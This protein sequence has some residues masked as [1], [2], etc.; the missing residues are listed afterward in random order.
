[1]TPNHP[2]LI[3]VEDN[4][5]VA[6]TVCHLAS[7]LGFAP[8]HFSSATSFRQS[9]TTITPSAIILDLGLPDDD[10]ITLID[11]IH[12]HFAASGII[13]MSGKDPSV[14]HATGELV[15]THGLHLIGTLH[16]PFHLKALQQLLTVVR[17]ERRRAA[18]TPDA[19]S[20]TVTME[21]LQ[22]ALQN[23]QFVPFYQPQTT[24]IEATVVGFE[25]LMRWNHPQW[26]IVAP[27]RFIHLAAQHRLL[28]QMTWDMLEQVASH[29][30]QLAWSKTTVSV[31]LPASFLSQKKLPE[32][33]L[34][35]ISRYGLD[36]SQLMLEITESEALQDIPHQL[37]NLIRLRLAGFP[38]SIDDFGTGY[39]S[40]VSLYQTPFQELK[41]DQ[42]F[43][44]RADNDAIALEIIHTL[45]FL[46]RRLNIQL[47]AEGVETESVRAL[48]IDAGVERIQGYLVHKPMPFSHLQR[49]REA[50]QARPSSAPVAPPS[51]TMPT[52]SLSPK[53]LLATVRNSLTMTDHTI[54][55]Q[56]V[57]ALAAKRDD[58]TFGTIFKAIFACGESIS[59]MLA[60]LLRSEW[61]LLQQTMPEIQQLP[62]AEQYNA[63]RH[64]LDFFDHL[65]QL[66]VEVKEQCWQQE[67]Q[68]AHND[69]NNEHLNR[70]IAENSVIWLR[71]KKVKLTAYF[72]EIPVSVVAKLVDIIGSSVVVAL[73]DELAKVLSVNDYRALIATRD[74]QEKIEVEMMEV[75]KGR[76]RL[77]MGVITPNHIGQ[78]K[79]VRVRHPLHP[80]AT[81]TIKGQQ[82]ITAHVVDISISGAKLTLPFHAQQQIAKQMAVHCQFD[83]G[84]D[85]LV[86]KGTIR[87]LQVD[88]AQQ[89][90][91]CGITLACNANDQRHLQEETLRLQR[92]LIAQLN[93]AKLPVLLRN[94]L[95]E[96]KEA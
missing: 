65:R 44:M 70:V 43:V 29:W 45:V 21:M 81:L 85:N 22:H 68:Q 71:R 24:T 78:R 6:K 16:K 31:N 19:A 47:I 56:L 50:Y 90:C 53:N 52:A 79:H 57:D 32:K 67:L 80:E 58:E 46:A 61:S 9:P 60:L 39:S 69:A 49:W 4:P 94:A 23:K 42:A 5:N 33:I 63:I 8:Q 74:G 59:T 26:G 51:S 2:L 7:R 76:V 72:E 20:E 48:L 27:G 83:I 14:I 12:S 92:D 1:M 93:N 75:R 38:L 91:H 15:Q 34:R 89:Q 84:T 3:V 41:I 95:D 30:Q 73:D 64:R 10:G 87:W 18:R 86:G 96:I 28:D 25:A 36:P 40:L 82:P 55:K 13:I 62:D 88:E 37:K 11:H 17:G 66:A 77:T 35:L 54:T